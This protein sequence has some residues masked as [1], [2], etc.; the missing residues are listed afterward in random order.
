MRTGTIVNTTIFAT[1][2]S[3]KNEGKK[4]APGMQQVKKAK[5]LALWPEE[6]NRRGR[7]LRAGEFGDRHGRQRGLR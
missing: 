4:R 3:T 6:R 5:R 1:P 2:S 7:P